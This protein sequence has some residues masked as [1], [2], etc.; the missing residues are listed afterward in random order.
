MSISRFTKVISLS[1][2]AISIGF[3]SF[4][5]FENSHKST[6]PSKNTE[7][8]INPLSIKGLNF[9]SFN[10]TQI[11]SKII[12]EELKI[13]PRK[14]YIFNV[15]PIK[16]I[17]VN[18]VTVEFYKNVDN[19][20]SLNL[21]CFKQLHLSPSKKKS[22]NSQ[23][24]KRKLFKADFLTRGVINEFVLKIYD[25]K[26]MSFLIKAS[27]VLI[28]FKNNRARLYDATIEDIV[29]RKIIRNF[30]KNRRKC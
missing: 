23:E 13:N 17:T 8:P 11:T 9:N 25:K 10:G 1:F 18:N 12:A 26:S 30:G 29:S 5:I 21:N 7:A 22:L 4:I 2:L 20:F 6:E 15:K 28:N 14:F 16:E 24:S 3:L 27:T 19:P